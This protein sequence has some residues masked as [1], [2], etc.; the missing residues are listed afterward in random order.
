MALA[1]GLLRGHL[2]DA[3]FELRNVCEYDERGSKSEKAE[4]AAIPVFQTESL[5]CDMA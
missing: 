5:F 4:G 1:D 2:F 3:L